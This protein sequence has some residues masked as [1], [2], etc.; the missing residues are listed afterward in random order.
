VGAVG[1]DV[2]II[3]KWISTEIRYYNVGL[4]TQ[5]GP[6]CPFKIMVLRLWIP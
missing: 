1:I 2:K 3:L 4:M 5:D 6:R